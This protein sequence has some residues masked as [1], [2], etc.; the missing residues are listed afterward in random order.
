MDFVRAK[1]A[2]GRSFRILTV[3]DQ[4]TRECVALAADRSMTGAK[5]TEAL[6]RV[7]KQRGSFARK[8]YRG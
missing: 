3:I 7:R 6:E 8:H 5:V 1:F 4:F 2:D